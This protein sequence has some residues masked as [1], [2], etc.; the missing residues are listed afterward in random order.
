MHT[1]DPPRGLPALVLAGDANRIAS[2]SSI[3]LMFF[4]K[5]L[6]T[7]AIT[8]FCLLTSNSVPAK[9]VPSVITVIPQV[10]F[11][12]KLDSMN[13]IDRNYL[14]T[15]I[16]EEKLASTASWYG[17]GFHGRRTASGEVFNSYDMT[18]AH[19][20]LPFGTR[21]R[22]TNLNNGRSVT[23]RITDRGP[24]VAGRSIDLSEGAAH[25]IGL[26]STGT[27]PIRLEVIR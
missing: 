7:I 3:N 5:Q 12:E 17:P 10:A 11:N 19:R 6:S 26:V 2:L 20:S 23:V 27:A 13:W 22:V 16:T 18:A 21:V 8:G 1:L 15:Q 14:H 9:A 4:A 24:Y 25:R